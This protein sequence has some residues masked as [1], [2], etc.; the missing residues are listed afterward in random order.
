M[1][2]SVVVR[3]GC[4]RLFF[5]LGPP[6]LGDLVKDSSHSFVSIDASLERV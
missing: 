6:F 2:N 3:A 5:V 1:K 4:R